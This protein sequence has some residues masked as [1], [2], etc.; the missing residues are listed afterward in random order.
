MS[1]DR[2]KAGMVERSRRNAD[3]RKRQKRRSTGN[4]GSISPAVTGLAAVLAAGGLGLGLAQLA[5]HVGNPQQ[6]AVEAEAPESQNGESAEET[7]ARL[8]QA[9]AT[10]ETTKAGET[11]SNAADKA[12][13]SAAAASEKSESQAAGKNSSGSSSQSGGSGSGSSEGSG[14]RSTGSE[15]ASSGSGSGAGSAEAGGSGSGAGSTGTTG[16]GSSTGSTGTAGSGSSTG[17]AGTAGG[18]SAGSTGTTGGSNAGSAEAAGAGSGSGTGVSAGTAGGSASGTAQAGGNAAGSAGI[19]QTG[20]SAADQAAYAAAQAAAAQQA[21]AAQAAQAQAAAQ[22]MNTQ[23]ELRAQYKGGSVVSQDTVNSVGKQ[24]FFSAQPIDDAVFARIQGKSYAN[25]CTVSLDKLRYVRI[26]YHGFDGQTHVGEVICNT[27]LAQD[28]LEI[29]GG[30]Y[31]A[32]YPIES[33]RLIDEFGANDETSSVANNSSSFNFRYIEGT[34]DL[35]LHGTGLA[36]DIN[37]LYNPTVFT[38]GSGCY[39]AAG[40]AYADR[41]KSFAHKIDQS[42][43]CYQLFVQHGWTWGGSWKEDPAYMHFSKTW[44]PET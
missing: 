6:Q 32:G 3:L 26:L 25:G 42:D 10:P 38:D 21:Q 30:L 44:P 5:S 36:I 12:L 22:A 19:A 37:P 33:V 43:L 29:F 9:K 2:K 27:T 40:A 15:G 1:K 39:P 13:E 28:L 20:G 34:T 41:T 18:S 4:T 17:N 31:D 24:A 11:E 14:S 7:A 8:A 23:A 35:S 16:G